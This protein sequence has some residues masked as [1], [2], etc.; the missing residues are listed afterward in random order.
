LKDSTT[1]FGGSDG[2]FY[3]VEM[4]SGKVIGV[5]EHAHNSDVYGLIKLS[6]SVFAS[7][8]FD[9]TVKVWEM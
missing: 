9:G 4:F 6:N 3:H 2:N 8:S 1:V 7:C 5:L